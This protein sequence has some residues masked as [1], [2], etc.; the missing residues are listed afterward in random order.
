MLFPAENQV[1]GQ[2]F[3]SKFALLLAAGFG[4][5]FLCEDCIES[6]FSFQGAFGCL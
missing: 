6:D 4:M 3:A 1:G 2:S 5:E